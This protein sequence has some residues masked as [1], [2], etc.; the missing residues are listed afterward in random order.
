MMHTPAESIAAM[1]KVRVQNPCSCDH[2]WQFA[3]DSISSAGY[4]VAVTSRLVAGPK[5]IM[6]LPLSGIDDLTW[7]LH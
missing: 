5:E 6:I 1:T 7:K 4:R 2:K 3:A